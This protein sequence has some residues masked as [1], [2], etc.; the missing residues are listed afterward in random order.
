MKQWLSCPTPSS[1]T[2]LV[3]AAVVM[4]M[5]TSFYLSVLPICIKQ[6]NK[7]DIETKSGLEVVINI[8]VISSCGHV[9]GSEGPF[10][11]FGVQW[12]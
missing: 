2:L 1:L 10:G 6:N 12:P 3:Q 8:R 5:F 4:T 11:N 9:G 7:I